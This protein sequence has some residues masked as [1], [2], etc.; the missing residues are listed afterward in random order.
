MSLPNSNEIDTQP[1]DTN[2]PEQSLIQDASTLFMFSKNTN[3]ESDTSETKRHL[4]SHSQPVQPMQSIHNVIVHTD[5]PYHKPIHHHATLKSIITES[6]DNNSTEN[7]ESNLSLGQQT[8]FIPNTPNTS[9]QLEEAKIVKP[10]SKEKQGVKN[11][12]WTVSDSYIVDPDAGIITCVCGYDE[13]DGFTIQCDHCFRWQ[14]AICYNIK[15]MDAVPDDYLCNVCKPRNIDIKLAKQIQKRRFS[16]FVSLDELKEG[17]NGSGNKKKRRTDSN[18]PSDVSSR[19]ISVSQKESGK[20]I[21]AESIPPSDLIRRKEH[22]VNAKDAYPAVYVA[23]E[24]SSFKDPLI[25]D[26]F[27][28]HCKDKCITPYDESKLEK[29]I[30]EVRPYSSIV[31]SRVFPGFNKLGIFVSRPCTKGSFVCE[32]IGELSFKNQY[33]NDPKNQYRIWGMPKRRVLFH[34]EWP[35]VLDQRL[36]GNE[37]RYLRKSCNPNVEL[38]TTK[39][40]DGSIKFWY[41]ALQDIAEDE[42]L[43]SKWQWNKNHPILKLI[44]DEA[45][46]SD[47]DNDEKDSLLESVDAILNSCECACG[48]NNKDC[49]IL[50]MKKIINTYCKTIRSKINVRYKFNEILTKFTPHQ[51]KREPPILERMVTQVKMQ[52]KEYDKDIL[53][54]IIGDSTDKEIVP[55][56][57]DRFSVEKFQTPKRLYKLGKVTH[58][59]KNIKEAFSKLLNYKEDTINDLEDLTIPI[60]L[61]VDISD[62]DVNLKTATTPSLTQLN[63]VGSNSNIKATLTD[64]DTP[65]S[66]HPADLISRSSTP[67]S[68]SEALEHAAEITQDSQHQYSPSVR[69]KKKLSFA[70]YKKKLSK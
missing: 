10:L 8:I 51:K 35:I 26:F 50:K 44:N 63:T 55:K 16:S 24:T 1:A 43:H 28:K 6:S 27:A 22:L 14:H 3:S 5:D 66:G 59:T 7:S 56:V 34:D 21:K 19:N 31:Y 36:S 61:A 68:V 45:K 60:K 18:D 64:H 39:A 52:Q 25:G 23:L 29:D 69:S 38:V 48:S 42:E 20:E 65:N 4:V 37:S 11:N 41:R 58:Q 49:H 32:A 2:E 46:F 13:D 54:Y 9:E 40:P 67:A 57:G 12:E 17:E 47:L 33:L 62:L 30:T 53:N 15:N 70:D